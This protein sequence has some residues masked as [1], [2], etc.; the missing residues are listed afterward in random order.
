MTPE[1]VRFHAAGHLAAAYELAAI[2]H[3]ESATFLLQLIG[4]FMDVERV[5]CPP[6]LRF[7]IDEYARDPRANTAN[8]KALEELFTHPANT[9]I[10][11]FGVRLGT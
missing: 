4:K 6:P 7:S 8:I 3:A 10:E 5:D 11:T 1:Q 2:G 9:M